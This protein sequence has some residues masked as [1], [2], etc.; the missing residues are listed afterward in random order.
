MRYSRVVNAEMP[1]EEVL[2]WFFS[3]CAM[4]EVELR[5]LLPCWR[6]RR[7]GCSSTSTSTDGPF[8]LRACCRLGLEGIVSKRKD[9]RYSSGRSPHRIKSKNPNA[10]AVKWLSAR[11][12][13]CFSLIMAVRRLT[14]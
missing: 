6:G 13:S 5:T 11:F 14:P 2:G 3:W 1:L 9:S 4:W 12:W 7:R 10:P 8:G